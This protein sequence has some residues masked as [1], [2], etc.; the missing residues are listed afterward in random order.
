MSLRRAIQISSMAASLLGKI[1][2]VLSIFRQLAFRH[3]T[4]WVMQPIQL[5]SPQPWHPLYKK[6]MPTKTQQPFDFNR[7]FVSCQNYE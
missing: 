3:A 2:R 1:P 5:V 7:F 6:I 4:A